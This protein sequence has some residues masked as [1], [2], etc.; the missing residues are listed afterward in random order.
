MPKQR[1]VPLSYQ[2]PMAGRL[3]VGGVC[4]DGNWLDGN[5]LGQAQRHRRDAAIAVAVLLSLLL[6]IGGFYWWG[7]QDDSRAFE[8]SA[9]QGSPI[10]LSL[11]Q[12]VPA[13]EPEINAV[14]LA[15]DPGTQ[16]SAPQPSPAR[17]SAAR[18]VSKR[19]EPRAFSAATTA[20]TIAPITAPQPAPSVAAPA[21]QP[22]RAEVTTEQ[23]RMR[24]LDELFAH[25]ERHKF[26]PAV[27]RRQGLEASVRVSFVLS[28]TGRIEELSII[29]GP[30]LLRHAA[31]Q[32]LQRA[33][34][35]PQ[36]P[37][38]IERPLRVEYRMAFALR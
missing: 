38:E 34:P 25:I 8:A 20:P 16:R 7:Q 12:S 35:L 26:Y 23:R 28:A 33:A 19:V 22:R 30:K 31:Q 18:V 5:W 6:H 1:P 32:T 14:E 29:D 9:P 37:A 4:V 17:Q 24:Y 13:S 21:A 36:P 15:A 11:V 27:A 3:A 2:P 10:H